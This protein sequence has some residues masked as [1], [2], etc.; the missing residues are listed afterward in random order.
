MTADSPSAYLSSAALHGAV[1]ALIFLL[2]MQL[3]RPNEETPVVFEVVAG[4]GN[5]YWETEAPKL[6]APEGSDLVK[7]AIPPAPV[8]APEPD[9]ITPAPEPEPIAPAAP[10]P[11]VKPVEQ[12]AA[13]AKTE[14]KPPNFTKDVMRLADKRQANI[15]KKF[16]EQQRKAE[17]RAK[18]Q[19]E[20]DAKRLTKEEFD[21]LN[22]AKASGA[23]TKAAGQP[24]KVPSIA[25]GIRTGVTEGSSSNDRGGAGGTAAKVAE[26]EMTQAYIAMILERIRQAMEQAGFNDLLRVR[27]QFTVSPS[28]VISGAGI[29]ESSGSN[30]FDRAVID[31]FRAIPNLGPPPDRRGGTFT[32]T[33]RMSERS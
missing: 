11:V 32:V 2:G 20:L 26:Q 17:E 25:K 12:K 9:P 1:A 7:A 31:A 15:E 3:N 29:L 27:V 22:K 19:A 13:V 33:L 4:E 6:G 23:A 10:P 18:K 21:R 5:R 30:E 16:R 24:V 8:R 14:P 28:G